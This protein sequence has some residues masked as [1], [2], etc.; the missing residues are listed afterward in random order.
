MLPNWVYEQCTGISAVH[1]E[2]AIARQAQLTKP[3][4]A[5]GRLEQVAI[6]LAGLQQTEQPRAARVP[7]II[8]AGD[9]GIVAQGVS[10]YPQ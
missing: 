7:I 6:D 3:T 1:R 9:H 8:F 10:A 4:G 5:L 2:A